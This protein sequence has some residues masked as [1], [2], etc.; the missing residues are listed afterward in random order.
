MRGDMGELLLAVRRGARLFVVMGVV[1]VAAVV[2]GAQSGVAHGQT[3]VLA[4]TQTL[5]PDADAYVDSANPGNNY[6]PLPTLRVDALSPVQRSFLRFD[7]S[8]VTGT[9]TK[10]TL[11]VYPESSQATGYSV[12]GVSNTTWGET[13]ITDSNAPVMASSATGS[14]GPATIN[15]WTNVVVTPLVA[16][17]VGHKVSFGLKTTNSTALKMSSKDTTTV[18]HK[19][20]LVVE[21]TAS[22]DTQA[23]T[24]PTGLNAT[25]SGPTT[26]DLSWNAST[27]NVGVTGYSIYKDG[28]TT[29]A[30]TVTG[31]TYSDTSVTPASTHSY[32]VDAFDA[33]GNH[34]PK[35]APTP[36][37]TTP[38]L[39]GCTTSTNG[40][41][42][43][44]TLCLTAPAAGP[45]S[46]NVQVSATLST[47]SLNGQPVTAR[48]TVVFCLDAVGSTCPDGG[49]GYLLSDYPA[50]G[51]TMYGFTLPTNQWV[52]A[53]HVL[54]ARVE[55]SDGFASPQPTPPLNLT[56]NNGVTTPPTNGNTFAPTSGTSPGAGQP[57][58][59]A[60]VG[61]GASGEASETSV[62]TQIAG[63]NPN[64]FLYL[65][66]VYEKGSP[67][68]FSN[69]YGSA[70][71]VFGQLQ[72]D[73]RPDRRQPRVQLRQ[74]GQR[75]LQLLG[76]EQA[77]LQL[78][79]RRLALHQPRLDQPVQ[80][81]WP[82]LDDLAA[83]P[84]AATGPG[85]RHV[86]VHARLL[87]PPGLEH[88]PG[89]PDLADE[90]DLV[91]ARRPRRRA[92]AQRPR[93]R[94]P[95]L[96]GVGRVR[97]RK[98]E[99]RRRG[100]RRRRRSRHSANAARRPRP[101]ANR[102]RGR[103]FRRAAA[104]AEPDQRDDQLLDDQ[105]HRDT[106]RHLDLHL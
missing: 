47:N 17:A 83:V 74:P 14:S 56:F 96:R 29:P 31:T 24:T 78:R 16:A 80:R 27:D 71:T 11:Y 98:P 64:L 32:T 60:A 51:K 66:D 35:T 87:P 70:N 100:R 91:A 93:P 106:V 15:I 54:R 33:V 97:Q 34:S 18:A 3:A 36:P 92:R 77:L 90:P 101:A 65:G 12:Y 67:S 59:V 2:G 72:D 81:A 6:G 52:D 1:C 68:E 76:H 53:T 62:V 30:T 46:G 57:L 84:V 8:G 89:G 5:F 26:I 82:G 88:R 104:P 69:Y 105:Q 28:G 48:G 50:T 99:R 75:L 22:G 25:A 43:S 42:Y 19:P 94:L 49:S 102:Q 95:A 63:W 13:T 86:A 85:R 20:Y 44:V 23:P 55:M 73:H 61:D 21:T 58:V 10:A 103:P 9:V 41:I 7:L 38:D 79:R 39:P 4:G 40:T 45:V 37:V